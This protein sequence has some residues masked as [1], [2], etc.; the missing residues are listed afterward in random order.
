MIGVTHYHWVAEVQLIPAD[1][2]AQAAIFPAWLTILPS[3]PTWILLH[4]SLF[5][6]P[7]FSLSLI[8]LSSFSI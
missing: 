1:E 4:V 6:Y 3:H 2:I 5:F 7:F 8:F